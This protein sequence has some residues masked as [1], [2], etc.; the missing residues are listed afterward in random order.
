MLILSRRPNE[1]IVFPSVGITVQIARICGNT[2]RV[3]VEAP[4]E[5]QVLRH[6]LAAA[7]EPKPETA[8]LD[9][10]ANHRLRN[11]LNKLT[12]SLH[13]ARKQAL[14]GLVDQGEATLAN[15]LETLQTLDRDWAERNSKP[16]EVVSGCHALIVEDDSNERELLAGL[17][18]MNGCKCATVENGEDALAF[19]ESRDPPQV[20]VLDMAMPRCD[21]PT[22]VRRLRSSDRH[23]DL[24][25]LAVSGTDPQQLG[26]PVGP[27]GIDAWFPKPLNPI[28]LWEAI[29]HG[30]APA[31]GVN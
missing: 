4:P 8:P 30:P 3:G 17:L 13:L 16:N 7:A 15:A 27:G 6:E 5:I 10:E 23:R 19:L 29:K 14:A 2:V 1:K 26:V 20:V 24:R 25:V 28:R 21:G 31:A 18:E 12:L 22:T 9:A 11:V